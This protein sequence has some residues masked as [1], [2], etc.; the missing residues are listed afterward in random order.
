V[1]INFSLSFAAMGQ[2]DRS[3][4]FQLFSFVCLFLGLYCLLAWVFL[5]AQCQNTLSLFWFCE[6]VKT[7]LKDL[8][9]QDGGENNGTS[10]PTSSFPKFSR[11][12]GASLSLP[13]FSPFTTRETIFHQRLVNSPVVLQQCCC[14]QKKQKKVCLSD[15]TAFLSTPVKRLC[16]KDNHLYHFH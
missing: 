5:H 14:L 11:F 4:L 7:P 12:T 8:F 15:P 13:R 9:F 2:T 1:K 10:S 16:T 6:K 3:E